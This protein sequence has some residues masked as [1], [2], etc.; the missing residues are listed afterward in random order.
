VLGANTFISFTRQT[1]VRAVPG[2]PSRVFTDGQAFQAIADE[3]GDTYKYSWSPAKDYVAG[4]VYR[5]ADKTFTSVTAA[6]AMPR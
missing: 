3:S 4:K 6:H 1:A 5:I 2:H